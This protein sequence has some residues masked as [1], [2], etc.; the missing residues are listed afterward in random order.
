MVGNDLR[1]RRIMAPAR[2]VMNLQGD[3]IGRPL[4]EL[5]TSFELPELEGLIT[6]VIDQVQPRE[7]EVRDQHGAWYLLRMHPLPYY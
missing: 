3:Y 2:R 7:I 1:L 6:E 5:A 4:R